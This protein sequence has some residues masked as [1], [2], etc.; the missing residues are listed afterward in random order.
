LSIHIKSAAL[1]FAF[2]CLF[3][4]G[5]VVA[6][7]LLVGP[8]VRAISHDV[9]LPSGKAIKITACHFAWG[10]EH[11]ERH[12]SQDSFTLE[13]VST[14]PHTDLAAVDRETVETFEL[15]RPISELWG[16]NVANVSAFQPYNVRGRTLSTPFHGMRRESGT[17]SGRRQRCSSM[18]KRVKVAAHNPRMHHDLYQRTSSSGVSGDAQR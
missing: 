5:A 7:F 10:V 4:V 18:I 13:Y 3:A 8:Q 9:V 1:G 6:V 11:G 14:V 12:V 2:A 15:I 17:L 16:L